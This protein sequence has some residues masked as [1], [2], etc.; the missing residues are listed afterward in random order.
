MS[1]LRRS[2]EPSKGDAAEAALR[3]G[4]RGLQGE[5][6]GEGCTAELTTP[7]DDDESSLRRSNEPSKGDAAEAALRSGFR[8]LQS[9]L[10][11]GR[12]HSG[13]YHTSGRRRE[14][15][16]EIQMNPGRG[17]PRRLPG[18]LGSKVSKVSLRE[19]CFTA[20]PTPPEDDDDE[21]AEEVQRILEWG[22][23]GGCPE[24]WIR[25][26]PR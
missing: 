26:S 7:E 24:V 13:V 3:S 11:G 6:A 5:L 2:N 20:D 12:L 1:S 19:E 25:K 22:C 15:A 23:R 8:G 14:L 16:E 17:M 18:G 4:C 10:A 9:E 21:L